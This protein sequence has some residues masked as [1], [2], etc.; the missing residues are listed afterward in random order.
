[1]VADAAGKYDDLGLK[2]IAD[3]D[4]HLGPLGGLKTALSDC[5]DVS[6]E[7]W[8]LLTA[9]DLANLRAASIE[10]L[11]AHVDE[12]VPC[13]AY[14]TDDWQPFPAF[15]HTSLLEQVER[16][17]AT[18]A[19]AMRA[20]FDQLSGKPVAPPFDWSSLG[21]VNTPD[22]LRAAETRHPAVDR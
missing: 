19:R 11:A 2:T 12:A 20:L 18:G 14:R 21:Q 5:R 9:C 3:H 17:L 15:Y 7:G 6:G 13:V 4:P 22:D 1:M 16:M 8:T 10:P